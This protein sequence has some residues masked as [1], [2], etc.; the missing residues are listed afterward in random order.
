MRL[1]RL[2]LGAT[3]Y[4]PRNY[5]RRQDNYCIQR[6]IESEPLRRSLQPNNTTYYQINEMN[7][8]ITQ[9]FAE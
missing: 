7:C 9:Q 3:I 4:S 5:L 1:V 8:N 6:H 2:S